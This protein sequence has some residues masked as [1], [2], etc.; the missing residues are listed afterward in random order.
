MMSPALLVAGSVYGRYR[1]TLLCYERATCFLCTFLCS[2]LAWQSC[3]RPC[4][5]DTVSNRRGAAVCTQQPLPSA[6]LRDESRKSGITVV[7]VI[8]LSGWGIMIPVFDG[9]K[10]RKAVTRVSCEIDVMLVAHTNVSGFQKTLM[11]FCKQL[12]TLLTACFG[13]VLI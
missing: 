9:N 8:P 13:F 1:S 5:K 2:I 6:P 3:L 12:V 7:T 11:S 4:Q 10:A